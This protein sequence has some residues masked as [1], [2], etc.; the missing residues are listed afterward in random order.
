VLDKEYHLMARQ[1]AH[2]W[3]YQTKRAYLYAVLQQLRLPPNARI[4]ELGS[5]V[6]ANFQVLR[7]FGEVEGVDQSKTGLKLSR[8]RFPETVHLG[9]LNTYLPTKNTYDLICILD[10][11]YHQLISSDEKVIANAVKGLRRGGYLLITDCAHQWLLG[12]HDVNN[13][14][15]KRYSL[16]E[17][18]SKVERLGIPIVRSSYLFMSVFPFFVL[19]RMYEKIAG[20]SHDEQHRPGL[21]NSFLA[22]VGQR[23]ARA[24]KSFNLPFGSSILLLAQ[25]R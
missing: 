2:N 16:H 15:R 14:A 18:K 10:V 1:Q 8:D 4:L 20:Y 23:E 21:V 17:L 24:L 12:P 22:W 13:M 9:D 19:S 5:G 6:G 25:K 3:W 11:L 7:Q